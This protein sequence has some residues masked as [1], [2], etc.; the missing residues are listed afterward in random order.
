MS[1]T[2]DGSRA[3]MYADKQPVLFTESDV[4]RFRCVVNGDNDVTGQFV[5][6]VELVRDGSPPYIR[7][8]YYRLQLTNDSFP[9]RHYFSFYINSSKGKGKGNVDLYSAF[10]QTPLTRSDMVH[11]VLPANNTILFLPV[12]IPQAAPPRIHAQRTPELAM[13]V[14]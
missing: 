13:H 12:S 7:D 6:D 9:I 10:S 5:A 11:T 8:L 14:G 2:L 1:E 4:R 3:E